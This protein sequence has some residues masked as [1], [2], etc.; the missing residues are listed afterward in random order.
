MVEERVAEGPAT[1]PEE[2][3]GDEGIERGPETAGDGV[4]NPSGAQAEDPGHGGRRHQVQGEAGVEQD[5]LEGPGIEEHEGDGEL[6]QQGPVGNAAR[7]DAA[8]G[9]EER[10]V[11]PHRAHHPRSEEHHRAYRGGEDEAEHGGHHPAPGGSQDAFGS[12]VADLDPPGEFVEGDRAQ[13]DEIDQEIE[14]GDQQRA[15]HQGPGEAFGAFQVPDDVHGGVPPGIGVGDEHQGHGEARTEQEPEVARLRD[16]RRRDP[17]G[18]EPH[19]AEGDD[20]HDLGGGQEVVDPAAPA[21]RQGVDGGERHDDHRGEVDGFYPREQRPQIGGHR[22]RREGGGRR[23]SHSGRN[24]AGS[25]AGS[26]VKTPAEQVVLPAGTGKRRPEFAID[27]RPGEGDEAPHHPEEKRGE[28]GGDRG[29]LEAKAREDPG[30]D[31]VRHH[32]HGG[33]PEGKAE[34]PART[35]VAAGHGT[36]D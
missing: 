5:L 22:H 24:A 16:Q 13:D 31:H 19:A 3:E 21:D 26:G 34:P 32:E 12:Q 20:Q 6:Q 8:E 2:E 11:L 28:L 15:R 27:Q 36:G 30:P 17:P 18:Q 23:K 35:S 4:R 25:E 9:P 29:D 1:H 14:D 33:G 10:L 7:A